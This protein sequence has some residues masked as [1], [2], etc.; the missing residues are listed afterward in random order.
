MLTKQ[1][2]LIQINVLIQTF[3]MF[4]KFYGH[5]QE[6]YIVQA[7]LYG[8]LFRAFM[9]AVYRVEG[10]ARCIPYKAVCTI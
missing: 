8:M 10:C 5:L 4:R 9:Q 7:A 2:T 6:D 3:Y 1:N